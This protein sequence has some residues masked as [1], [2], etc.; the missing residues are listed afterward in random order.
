MPKVKI[1]FVDGEKREWSGRRNGG[2]YEP[3]VRYEG[4]WVIVADE[5][6]NETAFP[7]EKVQKVEVTAMRGRW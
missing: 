5:Y 6:H 7:A 1:T 4:H 2:S 3:E